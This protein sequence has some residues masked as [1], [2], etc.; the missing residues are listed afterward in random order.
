MNLRE[1]RRQLGLTMKQVAERAGVSECLVCMVEKGKR[2]PSV[3]TA[4]KLAPVYGIEWA[5]FYRDDTEK[6]KR[7]GA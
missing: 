5:E 3:K 7:R 1:I 4:K 6:R 2:G